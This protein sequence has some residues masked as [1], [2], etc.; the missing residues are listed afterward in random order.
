[1]PVA[2][3]LTSVAAA[4]LATACGSNASSTGGATTGASSLSATAVAYSRCMRSHGVPEYPDPNSSGQLPKI[5][6]GNEQQLGVSQTRFNTAQGACQR[7]W[8][9]QAPTQAQQRS[10]LAAA[11]NFARC[12]RSR[13]LP[14][15]PDPT[16]D[17]SSG[18]VE[19]VIHTRQVS[20]NPHSPQTLA[21]VRDCE[22]VLPP[23]MRRGGQD[24][25]EA[26]ITP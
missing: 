8:P 15:F 19:F 23:S 21:K 12:M 18:R 7:L 2:A 3:V 9:Y 17:P 4:L 20:F 6:P 13:G 16:T 25:V 26:R 24:A 1:V 22:H 10:G 5:T 14:S 11:L